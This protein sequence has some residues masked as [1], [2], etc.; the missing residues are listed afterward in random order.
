M[1][2][3]NPTPTP[4]LTNGRMTQSWLNWFNLAHASVISTR[5][6]GTTANRPTDG[7]WIGR[8]YFDETLGVPIFVK[9]VNPTVWVSSAGDVDTMSDVIVDNSAKGL[10][11]KSPDAHYWRVTVDNSGV[12]TTTDLGLVKP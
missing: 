2:F 12:L 7:L 5:Q 4:I 1:S 8:Q 9:S 11:L 3:A 6:S 10:V